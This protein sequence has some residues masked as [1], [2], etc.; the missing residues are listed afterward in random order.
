MISTQLL[1]E[2]REAN[3]SYLLLAQQMIKADKPAAMFRLGVTQDV[4]DLLER[5]NA[6]QILKM[7]SSNMLLCRFRFDN[8][9]LAEM[10]TSYS[11][12]R[13]MASSHA[14]VLM[15]GQPAEQLAA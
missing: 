13:L 9:L 10:L 4:A 12:E 2:I 11:K 15:A 5:L 6:G 7:S 8:R 14:A 1:D 3:L